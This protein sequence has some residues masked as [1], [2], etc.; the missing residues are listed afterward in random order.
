[1]S[2]RTDP[3]LPPQAPEDKGKLTVCFELDDI[4]LFTYNPDE[5][6]GYLYQPPR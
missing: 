5:Y 6:E 3:I 1:V 4:L 2:V